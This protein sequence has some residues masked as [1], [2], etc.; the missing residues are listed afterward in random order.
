MTQKLI[1][2][3]EVLTDDKSVHVKTTRGEKLDLI[4][5]M[6]AHAYTAAII[7]TTDAIKVV[8]QMGRC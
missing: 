2:R 3:C 7:K 8:L 6:L 5:M 4:D 1:F